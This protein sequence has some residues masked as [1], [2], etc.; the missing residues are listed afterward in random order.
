MPRIERRDSRL[1]NTS[2]FLQN[3]ISGRLLVSKDSACPPPPPPTHPLPRCGLSLK[4]QIRRFKSELLLVSHA[5]D[6]A[7]GENPQF[8]AIASKNRSPP[9]GDCREL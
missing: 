1:D 8:T 6:S 5:C 3:A 7:M 2:C 9:P 4:I